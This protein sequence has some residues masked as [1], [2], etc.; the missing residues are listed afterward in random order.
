M[1]VDS[2]TLKYQFQ[3]VQNDLKKQIEHLQC[4]T[5][6]NEIKIVCLEQ[7][8]ENEKELTETKNGENEILK[9]KLQ[10]FDQ[11]LKEYSNE[12]Q[13][14]QDEV[15]ILSQNLKEAKNK[16]RESSESLNKLNG[17]DIEQ[18]SALEEELVILK[19]SFARISQEKLE[20]NKTL[21]NVRGQYNTLCNRSY[22]NMFF[23]IGPLVLMVLY[24]LISNIFS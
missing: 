20:L 5:Q 2:R 6:A 18:F 9:E 23:Y 7:A 1:V 22:N 3:T 24:L 15:A 4:T 13:Q 14:L 17:V 8:L 19:E 21:E 12:R 16:L 11:K 10:H